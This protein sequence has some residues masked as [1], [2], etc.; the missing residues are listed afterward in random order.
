M[1]G[2]TA[3]RKSSSARLW[4]VLHG[5][6]ALPIW[7]FLFFVCLTGSIATVSHEIVWLANPA[8]RANAPAADAAVLGYDEVLAAVERQ[9]PGTR[10]RFISRPVKSI[11]ALTVAVTRP[12]G[13][14]ARLFVNP[15]TGAIQGEEGEFNFQQFVRA[16]HGWLLMPFE[17]GFPVGWY[18]VSALAIPLLGSL[19]TGIVVYKRFWRAFL[20]PRLRLG[21]GRRI[22]WGDLHRLAGAWSIPF[23][24]IM[25]VTAGWFLIQAVL[26]DNHISISTA[27]VPPAVARGDVPVVAKGAPAP[28]ISLDQAAEA[29]R[30]QLPDLEPSFVELPDNAYD[31]ITVGGRGA[32][33]LLFETIKVNPY[34]GR[35]EWMRRVS[36]R[37]V[38]ELVTGSMRPLHTGDFAG[39][40][41]KMVYFVFGL[42][43]TTLVFSGMMVWTKRTAVETV[44]LARERKPARLELEAA[45]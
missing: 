6:L 15:Y 20:R 28:R 14:S 38:L 40:W 41:L 33:P 37:S 10:V 16:L 19:I 30:A 27:G 8:M 1:S 45:E 21:K 22:F 26:E 23:I 11:F 39:V 44:K 3:S 35:V 32:Y 7:A 17:N 5:W 34:D 4:F 25:A 24:A 42:L 9:A 13:S 36:D 31:H 12:D 29:V 2:T 43:L 18:A